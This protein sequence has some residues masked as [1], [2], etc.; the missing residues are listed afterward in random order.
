MN[1]LEILGSSLP[2]VITL[3]VVFLFGCIGETISEKAGNLNL[4]IPGVM[5]F[6]VVGGGIGSL[7]YMNFIYP[8]MPIT[9]NAFGFVEFISYSLLI[10]L[11]IVFS[12]AFGALGGLIYSFLTTTLK[13]NQNVTG[14]ALTTFGAGVGDFFVTLMCRDGGD[15]LFE[16]AARI[17][18]THLTNATLGPAGTTFDN[19]NWHMGFIASDNPVANIFS[20]PSLVY[21]CFI[22][23][24]V[25]FIVLNKTRIGLSLRAVGENP[26][27]ADAAGINTDKYKYMATVI[28]CGIA[29]VGGLF[30]NMIRLQG[31]WNGTSNLQNL[32][33]MVLALVIFT[34]WNPLVAIMG[35]LV[36]AFLYSIPSYINTDMV[37]NKFLVLIPYIMTVVVLIFTSIFGK[38]NVLP[39]G[40]LGVNYFREER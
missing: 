24:I 14:L 4:G 19:S 7:I 8:A 20:Q 37:T 22:L 25:V 39:P 26:A 32:G 29:G 6:G 36:F 11:G 38:K 1:F 10:L 40:S 3:S 13:A 30:Y 23:A 2:S 17:Y 31:G 15:G 18:G 33:W 9:A 21:I 35:S 27:T 34:V 12:F 28:G 16:V 5:C